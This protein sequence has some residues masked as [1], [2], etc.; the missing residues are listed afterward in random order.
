MAGFRPI[1]IALVLGLM[2]GSAVFSVP[3]SAGGSANTA[4]PSI[5]GLSTSGSPYVGTTLT[6]SAGSWA[7]SR[8]PTYTYQWQSEQG[9][10]A[11]TNIAAATAPRYT[12]QPSDLQ[13][14]LRISVTASGGSTANSPATPV[15]T[16]PPDTSN[17]VAAAPVDA[18]GT[19]ANSRMLSSDQLLVTSSAPGTADPNVPN[20][21]ATVSGLTIKPTNGTGAINPNIPSTAPYGSLT[22]PIQ[23][24]AVAP[25]A[26]PVALRPTATGRFADQNADGVLGLQLV[27]PHQLIVAPDNVAASPMTMNPTNNAGLY[28]ST[29]LPGTAYSIQG[30]PSG[31]YPSALMSGA[32]TTN[33]VSWNGSG[34]GAAATWSATAIAGQTDWVMLVNRSNGLCLQSGSP[35]TVASCVWTGTVPAKL[36]WQLENRQGTAAANQGNLVSKAM[37]GQAVTRDIPSGHLVMSATT[38]PVSQLQG[39]VLV[40]VTGSDGHGKADSGGDVPTWASPSITLPD[41]TATAIAAADLDRVA[42]DGNNFTYHDEAVIAW[43]GANDVPQIRVLDYAAAPGSITA[44]APSVALPAVGNSSSPGSIALAVGDFDGDSLNEIA[45]VWQDTNGILRLTLLK[46]SPTSTGH[47]LDLISP[48]TGTVLFGLDQPGATN[49][50]VAPNVMDAKAGDFE[51]SGRDDLAVAYTSQFDGIGYDDLDLGVVSFIPKADSPT[52]G[53]SNSK[54]LDIPGQGPG[55]YDAGRGPKLAPGLFKYDPASGFTLGRRQLALAFGADFSSGISSVTTQVNVYT[56]DDST[57]CTGDSCSFSVNEL[58]VGGVTDIQLQQLAEVA[59]IVMTAGGFSGR[60]AQ[61]TPELWSLY[62]ALNN[63]TNNGQNVFSYD[64]ELFKVSMTDTGI[65]ATNGIATRQATGGAPVAYSVAAYDP[66]G[67]SLQLGAPA[68]VQI[69]NVEKPTMIAAQPPTHADWSW[70]Q[71]KLAGSTSGFFNVS[72]TGGLNVDVTSGGTSSYQ[73]TTTHSAGWNMGTSITNDAKASFQADFGVGSVSAGV[74]DKLALTQ[75]WNGTV[76][77]KQQ[78]SSSTSTSFSSTTNDIDSIQAQVQNET[79]YR[80]PILGGPVTGTNGNAATSAS[81]P[82]GCYGFYEVVI[83]GQMTDMTNVNNPNSPDFDF[84]Q[85]TWQNG[86]VFSYPP[87]TAAG[88]TPAN[89]IPYRYV[90][91]KTGQGQTSTGTALFSNQNTVGGDASDQ[92]LQITSSTGQGNSSSTGSSWNFS[93]TVSVN[94]S[95]NLGTPLDNAS[96]GDTFGFGTTNGQTFAATDGGQTVN[97]SGSGFTLNVPAIDGDDSYTIATNYYYDSAGTTRIDPGAAVDG[98]APGDENFWGLTYKYPDPALNLPDAVAL[99]PGT[100]TTSPALK[101]NPAPDSQAIRGFTV[102]HSSTNPAGGDT[103]ADEPYITDPLVGDNVTFS[104]PVDNYSLV[105]ASNVT[106]TFKAVAVNNQPGEEGLSEPITLGTQTVKSIP[107]SGS[108]TVTQPWKTLISNGTSLQTWQVFVII[109][110]DGRER[111]MHPLHDT[112]GPCPQ[113]DIDTNGGIGAIIDPFTGTNSELACGQNNQGFG[114]VTVSKAPGVSPEQ[115]RT[116]TVLGMA[117]RATGKTAGVRFNG[118]GVA[119]KSVDDPKSHRL[120]AHDIPKVQVGQR[121]SGATFSTADMS[122]AE[123]QPVVIYDGPVAAH[124]VVATTKLFGVSAEGFGRA[125]FTWRATTPGLHVFTAKLLGSPTAGEDDLQ[126]FKIMVVA[127][128]PPHKPPP[129]K[130]VLSNTGGGPLAMFMITGFLLVALGATGVVIGRRRRL[131]LG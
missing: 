114:V 15:V 94:A 49:L 118:V 3:A 20:S 59:P 32:S 73:H 113:G 117:S 107:P 123:I 24:I 112:N 122:S 50:T 69:S 109:N 1:R 97:T 62:V 93:N 41:A 119:T 79:V 98:G 46:Y 51:G 47:A 110:Q 54:T 101:F 80:Y 19:P 36:L 131:G 66:T 77:N 115:L 13:N 57:T 2:L 121:I 81:C 90:D 29:F 52:I 86:N 35:V 48:A 23:P 63:W 28:A 126:T 72:R 124:N 14:A 88:K 25:T 8:T 84:Y 6:A 74:E 105:P 92:A 27:N 56:V 43:V 67:D 31:S 26:E 71:D 111:E 10:G 42:V 37:N 128:S 4:P 34:Y 65:S 108:V 83:P 60:N 87:L 70:A 95:V 120:G 7:G 17:T 33:A 53:I 99:I 16:N 116:S 85:P 91:P 103:F 44:T 102:L 22:G 30:T 82:S 9:T 78:Y 127:A 5:I 21:N 39:F 96:L 12:V 125:D 75:N 130:P 45:F 11:W 64:S 100:S 18:L 55:W 38:S 76:A 61:G 68:I 106:V 104:V 40:P 129:S 89:G 58:F